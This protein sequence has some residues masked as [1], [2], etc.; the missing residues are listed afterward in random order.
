[1][2]LLAPLSFFFPYKDMVDQSDIRV[3]GIIVE[4]SVVDFFFEISQ[5]VGIVEDVNYCDAFR[6]AFSIEDSTYYGNCNVTLEFLYEGEEFLFG[7]SK[8]Y[9]VYEYVVLWISFYH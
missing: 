5:I 4:L 2:V 7:D 1:M 9:E 3:Y 8:P 6:D